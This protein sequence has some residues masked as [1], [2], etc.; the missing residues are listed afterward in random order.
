MA[1]S[2]DS[3]VP[4][5]SVVV[6]NYNKGPFVSH[7]ISSVLSQSLSNLE[8]IFVDDGSADSSASQAKQL[9]SEDPR[10]RI[11]EH[12]RR[13]GPAAARNTGIM[14]ACGRFI[15]LL[16]SDDVY[17]PDWLA[18]AVRRLS[19]E[20]G[21]CVAYCDWWLMDSRGNRLGQ[22]REHT[23][24]SGM[25]FGEFL[26]RSLEVNSVL[27][28]TKECFLRAG[29][30]DESLWWGEDYDFVLRA[31]QRFPFL[32]V[33]EEAYGYRLHSGNSW[34][35]FSKKELYRHKSNVLRRHLKEG[36]RLLPPEE[37]SDVEARLAMYYRRSDQSLELFRLEF[38]P[39]IR[40]FLTALRALSRT[41]SKRSP[42]LPEPGM[43]NTA[44]TAREK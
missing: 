33:D 6:P 13:R 37:M 18:H 11:L 41:S 30:Y 20:R 27:V 4:L 9:R 29:L 1:C 26:R 31:A 5:V 43:P 23:K 39:R 3:A 12:S 21:D 10:V 32:Y 17:S 25:L 36:R 40:R 15:A 22:K 28:A 8:L 35:K 42:A 24:S 16:D 34:R 14:A 7:A 38:V 19:S 44:P 2:D